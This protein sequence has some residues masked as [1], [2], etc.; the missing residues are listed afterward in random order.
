MVL[1]EPISVSVALFT[2]LPI[3]AWQ[4]KM[5][6]QYK[7][8]QHVGLFVYCKAVMSNVKT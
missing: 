4:K 1:P 8:A 3:L 2:V 6:A 7:V 5:V